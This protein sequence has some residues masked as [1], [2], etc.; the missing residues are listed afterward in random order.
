MNLLT[1][2]PIIKDQRLTVEFAQKNSLIAS[3]RYCTGQCHQQ[4][5]LSKRDNSD[6][7]AWRCFKC[8]KEKSIR[9]GS[10]FQDSRIPLGKAIYLIYF[11]SIDM[12]LKMARRELNL[13]QV[14]MVDWYRFC[15]DIVYFHFENLEDDQTMIGGEGKIVEIDES[16]FAKRKFHRGREVQQ[17]WMFGGIERSKTEFKFFVEIVPNRTELTLVEVINRR[18]QKNTWIISDKWRSYMHLDQHGFLH[19]SVNHSENFVDPINN[20]IYTQTIESR[21]SAMKRQIKRKG[22]N[23]T[24]HIEEYLFEYVYRKKIPVNTF[25]Q[26][27]LDIN[28]RY[29]F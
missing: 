1:L 22:T 16:L 19:D 18:I 10:F 13:N 21:W 26:L 8:R 27:I 12:T 23:L 5:N 25:E 3:R 29:R 11:W 6:G 9:Y 24:T 15:R 14:T 20:L 7:F 2:I 4:M 28:K 17:I